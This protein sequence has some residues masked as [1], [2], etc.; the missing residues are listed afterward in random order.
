MRTRLFILCAALLFGMMARAASPVYS[1]V[2][3]NMIN[4][5]IS[6]NANYNNRT[7][8]LLGGIST[9]NDGFGG[10]F[11]WLASSNTST[12]AT[13]VFRSAY[14]DTLSAQTST[15][16]LHR[17]LTPG[18]G[19]I[20]PGGAVGGDLSGTL[21]NPTVAK[22]NT[23]ALGTTT[24]TSGNLLI[25]D[26]SAWETKSLSGDATLASTGALT[27]S[28][29]IVAGGPTGSATVAPIITYDAKGRL[30]TVSSA[31]I[32]PAASSITGGSTLTAGTGLGS[33]SIMGERR[34]ESE[35]P[36]TEPSFSSRHVTTSQ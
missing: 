27:L 26:G 11:L 20:P 4:E 6:T 29:I 19:G 22:I 10:E 5:V 31:T 36:S 34:A 8:F 32:T 15:G 14:Y 35:E 24:A 25:A 33:G 28:S 16:R 9:T 12:N 7:T 18:P 13:N 3:T 1:P 30:T 21:P 2:L 23:V 17:L